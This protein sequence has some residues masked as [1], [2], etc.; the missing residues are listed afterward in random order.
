MRTS[1]RRQLATPDLA[2]T[3][4]TSATRTGAWQI[5][6]D[7]HIDDDDATPRCIIAAP[8]GYTTRQALARAHRMVASI[9]ESIGEEI[10]WV[11]RALPHAMHDRC[12]LVLIEGC[13]DDELVEAKR[14]LSQAARKAT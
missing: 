14:L 5:G 1:N 13:A 2:A 8:K 6:Q 4:L 11:P 3:L 10:A 9:Y 12:A 7:T